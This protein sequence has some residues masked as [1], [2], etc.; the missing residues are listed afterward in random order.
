M[1]FHN[2]GHSGTN[3][4]VERTGIHNGELAQRYSTRIVRL[5]DGKIVDDS[6]PLTAAR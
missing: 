6:N 2:R 1:P 3:R 5:R 4:A